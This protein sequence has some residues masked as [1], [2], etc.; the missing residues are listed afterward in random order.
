M[1]V[2]LRRPCVFLV[3]DELRNEIGQDPKKSQAGNSITRENPSSAAFMV[4]G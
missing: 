1:R 2:R 4:L 3:D